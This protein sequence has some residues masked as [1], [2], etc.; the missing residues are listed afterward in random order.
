MM[1]GMFYDRAKKMGLNRVDI[2][3][4]EEMDGGDTTDIINS[5]IEEKEPGFVMLMENGEPELFI[6]TQATQ[7]F[8]DDLEVDNWEDYKAYGLY[9]INFY[10]YMAKQMKWLVANVGVAKAKIIIDRDTSI[11][12]WAQEYALHG[13]EPDLSKVFSVYF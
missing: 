9:L 6:S 1:R 2:S 8:Y 7:T 11:P 13:T 3:F 12:K 4:L 5:L 10:L